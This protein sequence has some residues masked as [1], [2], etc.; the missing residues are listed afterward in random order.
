MTLRSSRRQTL[1]FL[2][3]RF[4]EAGIHPRTR[5]GQNFLVDLNLQQILIDTAQPGPGDVVLEVGTGTGSLA[6]LLAARAAAVVT[7]EVDRDLARLAAE[8]LDGLENVVLL[9]IDALKN[10][11]R[12]NQAVLDAVGEQLAAS[13]GR[14]LKLVA[15]LPYN[16]ATPVLTNLLAI[17]EPP[18]TMTATIQ[19]ELADR[20]VARP[21]TRDYGALSIWVQSQCRVDVVR[22]MPPSVFWPRP[23]VASAIVHIAL[24]E[25]LRARIPDREFFH[26]F[27]RAMFFHRRKLLRSG[28]ASAFK[29]RLAKPQADQVLDRLGLPRQTRAEELDVETMLALSEVVR[30]EVGN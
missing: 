3:R 26:G 4:E 28:L 14:Q 5:L 16:I 6:A 12:L 13:P 30:P 19:K 29:G 8:E 10:K 1:S 22:L 7:V 15:N 9:Q 23:K 11:N 25:R 27:V 17:D 2:L 20:I 18:R 24:D 21:G